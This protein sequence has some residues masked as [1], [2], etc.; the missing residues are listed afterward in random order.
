MT[1][2]DRRV[3]TVVLTAPAGHGKTHEAVALA[4]RIAAT[5]PPHRRVLFLAH[6]NA[7]VDEA[8]RRAREA[9]VPMTC[10]TFDA[11]TVELVGPYAGALGL[12][13]PLKVG[14]GGTSSFQ[15]V[16]EAAAEVV[17]RSP[18]IARMLGRHYPLVIADEHQDTRL[19]HHE[20]LVALQRAGGSLLRLFGDDMQVIYDF[21]DAARVDWT[22]LQADNACLTLDVPHRWSEVPELGV[23]LRDIR[24]ALRAGDPLPWSS[25]PRCVIRVP[26]EG[27]APQTDRLGQA[28]TVAV[29]RALGGIPEGDSAGFLAW[30]NTA[31]RAVQRLQRGRVRLNEGAG[32]ETARTALHD[33]I[34]VVGVPA[35]MARVAVGLLATLSVGCTADVRSRI[36]ACLGADAVDVGNQRSVAE[37][38]RAFE[39][40]YVSADL[41]TWS[42]CLGRMCAAADAGGGI[43][44]HRREPLGLLA[45][46][47]VP[48]DR[49]ATE[50]YEETA[51]SRRL[52]LTGWT[53]STIHGSKGLEFDHVV[54]THAGSADFADTPQGRA[55]FYTAMS[56]A[57]KSVTIVVPSEAPSPLLSGAQRSAPQPT[58]KRQLSLF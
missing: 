32:V 25:A 44:I 57:R 22:Q 50:V 17:R 40:L 41:A 34:G 23:W 13:A 39:P 1:L 15:D 52:P 37:L 19:E 9:H 8:S 11:F 47:R 6:T 27:R 35:D 2:D 20:L 49:D 56:R 14:P 45:S 12:A 31:V 5:L 24:R 55:L 46:L 58:S 18:A 53:A 43:V 36:E 33:V 7:A 26:M 16:S 30:R 10:K 4:G 3:P 51:R 38:A 42:A 29:R 48:A 28:A 21:E 54:I